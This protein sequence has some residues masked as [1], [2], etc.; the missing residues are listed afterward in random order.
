MFSA[1]VVGSER[2]KNAAAA[3][4][5]AQWGFDVGHLP[6]FCQPVGGGNQEIKG[7]LGAPSLGGFLLTQ[8]EP[9]RSALRFPASPVPTQ[10]SPQ[11]WRQGGEGEQQPVVL[12]LQSQLEPTISLYNFYYYVQ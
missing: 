5:S 8:E 9:G 2:L 11:R 3:A 4:G 7:Q 12:N 10:R 1:F 6:G